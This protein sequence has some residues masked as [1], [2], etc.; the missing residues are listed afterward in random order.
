MTRAYYVGY[1][2][3]GVNCVYNSSGWIVFAFGSQAKRERYLAQNQ[4]NA[5]GNRV[6]MLISHRD[7]YRI[8]KEEDFVTDDDW[9]AEI[10]N[11]YL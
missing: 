4:Y 2:R 7:A 11:K 8:A 6:M 3:Y 5:N 1:N 9:R 10:L